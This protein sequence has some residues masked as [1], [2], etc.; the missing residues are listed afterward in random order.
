MHA[1]NVVVHQ[2]SRNARQAGIHS[3]IGGNV[4]KVMDASLIQDRS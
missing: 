3:V 2:S 4:G 1:M